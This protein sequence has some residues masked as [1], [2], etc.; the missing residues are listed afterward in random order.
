MCFQSV[1]SKVVVQEKWMRQN[2]YRI[3]RSSFTYFTSHHEEHLPM[4]NNDDPTVLVLPSGLRPI[5]NIWISRL[6]TAI[7]RQ[8]P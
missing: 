4:P 7:I 8:M 5:M 3:L 1:K 6:T 2:S